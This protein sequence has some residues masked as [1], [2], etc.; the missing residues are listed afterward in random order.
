MLPGTTIKQKC[1]VCAKR[2]ILFLIYFFQ[3][4]GVF[5]QIDR[6]AMEQFMNKESQFNSLS[7]Q[8]PAE[9]KVFYH[10]GGY[11]AIWLGNEALTADLF[12]LLKQSPGFGL[13]QNDYQQALPVLTNT[14]AYRMVGKEDSIFAELRCTDAALHFI[15]DVLYGNIAP[16]TGYNGLNYFP[17]CYDIAALLQYAVAANQL[18][19][20]PAVIEPRAP[21]YA[22]MKEKIVRYSQMISDSAFKEV[23]I[24]S[25]KA[26]SANKPLLTKLFQLGFIDSARQILT[27]SVLKTKVKGV[28]KF[29][30]LL[31]DGVLRSTT[32]EAFNVPMAAR[33]R[34]LNYALNTIRWLSCIKQSKKIIVVNIPSAT[35]LV[36]DDGKVVL[37]SKIIVGKRSTPTP[38]LNSTV[39]EVVLYPYW[40]VPHSIA[41]KELLPSIKRNIGFIDANGY[42]VIN[43]LGE[44]VDHY[45]IDWAALSAS[46]FPYMIRQSTGC[47]NALG[48]VKLNF[49]N[50]YSVYLHDTPNKSLFG[51]NKRYFSHGCMR[52]EKAMDLARFVLKNNSIAID[53]LSEKGCLQ[54]QSP[55]IVPADENIPVFVLY[56]TAWVDSAGRVSFSEDIYR[57]NQFLTKSSGVSY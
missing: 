49:Y 29:F 56:N 36:Y 3:A 38:L 55:V 39:T 35:L 28:Q 5:A 50:P 25:T 26:D 37:E 32:M 34:E 6:T 52:V 2:A 7:L 44:I 47:D 17:A 46:D 10:N 12:R 27:D 53:T 22:A 23:K 54:N 15:H 33:L 19:S 20:L 24:V 1:I 48:L 4:T 41:T 43:R 51:L 13:D 42:Q 30:N 40:M 16:A 8:F 11:R 57:K 14:Q 9:T 45:K 21:E 31:S 18:S